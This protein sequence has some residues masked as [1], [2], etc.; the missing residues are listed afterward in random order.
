MVDHTEGSDEVH[1]GDFRADEE[2][3]GSSGGNEIRE[4][5]VKC[6]VILV[7]AGSVGL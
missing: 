7:L 3:G 6:L 5:N 2:R 4:Y 1:G